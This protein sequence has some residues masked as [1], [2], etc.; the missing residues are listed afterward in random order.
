MKFAWLLKV[1]EALFHGL[2]IESPYINWV[3]FDHPLYELDSQDLGRCS[4]EEDY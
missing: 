1:P 4:N 3:S 2:P